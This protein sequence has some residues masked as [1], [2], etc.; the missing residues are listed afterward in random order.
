MLGFGA[1]ERGGRGDPSASFIEGG[2]AEGRA[3]ALGGCGGVV[4]S[5]HDSFGSMLDCAITQK[6]TIGGDGAR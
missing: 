5:M 3:R 6:E 1:R 2:E 4:A